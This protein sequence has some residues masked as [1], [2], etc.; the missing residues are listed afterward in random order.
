MFALE[1][2]RLLNDMAEKYNLPKSQYGWEGANFTIVVSGELKIFKLPNGSSKRL[3]DPALS[4]I[5]S[6]GI[7]IHRGGRG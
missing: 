6:A 1:I 4:A 7:A 5:R 3:L 2:R